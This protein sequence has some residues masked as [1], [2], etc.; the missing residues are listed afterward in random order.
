[1]PPPSSHHTKKNPI[2]G[3]SRKRKINSKNE[4][5][6]NTAPLYGDVKE[7]VSGDEDPIYIP[8]DLYQPVPGKMSLDNLKKHATISL[9]LKN[10]AEAKYYNSLNGI[11]GIAKTALLKYTGVDVESLIKEDK[12]D[13]AYSSQIPVD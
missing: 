11:V 10:R 9:I 13:H 3:A 5:D 1:M 4:V 2:K 7:N 8:A 12:S 6:T